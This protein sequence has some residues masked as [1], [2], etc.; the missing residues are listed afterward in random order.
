MG[1]CICQHYSN[2][3]LRTHIS[4]TQ[5][6]WD[7]LHSV[8]ALSTNLLTNE[9]HLLSTLSQSFGISLKIDS[10]FRLPA[11]RQRHVGPCLVC[12]SGLQ[13]QQAECRH[14][15]TAVGIM[16]SLSVEATLFFNAYLWLV[17]VDLCVEWQQWPSAAGWCR[18]RQIAGSFAAFRVQQIAG[19]FAARWGTVLHGACIS[20]V[21]SLFPPIMRHVNESEC[22]MWERLLGIW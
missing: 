9:S 10:K 5:M 20:T 22:K 1:K 21:W 19:R 2:T 4:S 11:C 8:G 12:V 15:P 7:S 18:R 16:I 13:K 6:T 3:R 14:Q 17:E